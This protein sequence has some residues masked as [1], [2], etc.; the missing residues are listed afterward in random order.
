METPDIQKRDTIPAAPSAKR[1]R[2]DLSSEPISRRGSI[3]LWVSMI[4]GIIAAGV[5]FVYKLAEFIF[6][7]NSNAAKGFADVPVTIYFAV[8]AGWLVLLVWSWKTGKFKDI[9][10]AK[11]DMLRQEM[12]YERRGE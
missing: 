9:E 6:T 5:A 2:L 1:P 3:L 10:A 8:A 12:E 7:L 4:G 11:W